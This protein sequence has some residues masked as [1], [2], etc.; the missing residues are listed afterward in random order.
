MTNDIRYLQSKRWIIVAVLVLLFSGFPAVSLAQ[1]ISDDGWKEFGRNYWPTKPVRGGYFKSAYPKDVGLMNPNHWPVNDWETLA[2]IYERFVYRDGQYRSAIPYLAKSW[3]YLNPV[4]VVTELQPGVKFHD[5]SDLNAAAVKYQ[6]EWIMDRKNGCWDRA[7]LGPLKSVELMDEFTLKWHFKRP[8]AVFAGGVLAAVPGFPISAEALK[9]DGLL[10]DFKSLKGKLKS[11]AKKVK[12]AEKKAE[13]AASTGGKKASK[14]AAKLKK[15]RKKLA[16]I[17][18]MLAAVKAKVSGAKSTDVH[19]VGTGPYMLEENSP[20][21]YVKLKRNPNWWFA[22]HVGQPDMPY[23][24]GWQVLVI[25]DLSVQLANLRTGRIHTMKIDKAMYGMV[26]KDPN[27]RVHAYPLNSLTALAMNHAKGVCRDIRVRKAISHA[28][29]RRALVIGT[30]F[31]LSRTASCMYPQDH[32]S[33]NPDLKPVSYDPELSRKLLAEA[34]HADGLTIKGHVTNIPGATVLVDSIGNMLKKVG[35][36]W[37]ADILDRAPANDRFRNLEYDLVDIIY[38]YV[39]DPDLIATNLYHPDGGFNHSRSK[40]EKAIALIKA[41]KSE[42]DPQ[43]RRNVYFKLEE[44]LYRNYEDVWLWW[45]TEVVAYRNKVHGFNVE[46]YI[47]YREGVQLTHPLW[48]K[49]GK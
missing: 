10:K 12:K 39:Y 44:E 30:Q 7:F 45:G 33:H 42:I 47:K 13:A 2:N 18:R 32:W 21:N 29:N 19:P 38:P 23:F 1:G 6:M 40:N 4:T 49:D 22:K 46:M 16:K 24:D 11:A 37:K 41:G 34:G 25:P 48:F 35:I 17:E 43:K 26:K 14:A 5:G 36:T 3:K 8:W 28:I 27:L 20:G 9:K 31:G 15:E